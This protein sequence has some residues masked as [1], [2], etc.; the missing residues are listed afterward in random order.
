MLALPAAKAMTSE[1]R[2]LTV[3]GAGAWRRCAFKDLA[4]VGDAVQLA[5]R[6]DAE[7]GP[8]A[9]PADPTGAGLAFDSGCRLL[10]ARPAEG[11]VERVLWGAFDPLHPA[12]ALEAV[13]IIGAP[14]PPAAGDFAPAAV[15][16]SGFVPR[17]LACDPEDRLFI[18]DAAAGMIRVFDLV[19][20]RLLRSVQAP[21]GPVDIAWWGGRLYGLSAG[22][23][24]LWRMAAA[25]SL[26]PVEAP[27]DGLSSP[28]RLTFAADGRCF[29]LDKAHQAD[30]RIFEL[31]RPGRWRAEPRLVTVG[32][33]D[34]FAHASDIV[35]LGEGEDERLVIARR[36]DETFQRLDI[37]SSTYSLA[38]PLTARG[39][40]GA[41][42]AAAPDGR[43]AFWT[44]K[45][46]R[47]A[48]AARTRYRPKGRAVSFRLDGGA[49]RTTWGRVFLD[50]CIPPGTAIRVLSIVS[51]DDDEPLMQAAERLPRTPP[52][53]SDLAPIAEAAAT[54]MPPLVLVPAEEETGPAAVRRADGSEQPWAENL[55]SFATYEAQPSRARGR[56]LWL[57][58]DLSGT[59]LATP[60]LRDVRVER[61]GHDWL[62]RLPALYSRDEQTRGFL[63]AYLAPGAGLI[64]DTAAQ[65]D[66]RHAMLK[67]GS[68]P[69]SVLPWLAG[70]L[71]L[72]LD[73]R[74]PEAAQRT[75]IREAPALF[76]ARGTPA[77][78][79]RMVEI[80]AEAPAVILEDFRLRGQRQAAGQEA[81][82]RAP[83]V[84][85]GGFRVGGPIGEAETTV[86]ASPAGLA[87]LF[88]AAAHRFSILI[89]ADLDAERLAAVRDLLDVH[90]PAHTLV[91]VCT[92]GAGMRVG[93][94]LHV[95]ISSIIGRSADWR[96]L[97]AGA[98]RLG[99]EAIVGR[100]S[101]GLRAGTARLGSPAL[102]IG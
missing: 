59:S 14:A 61:P 101:P 9:A 34:A 19:A 102:R 32:A 48:V 2:F 45:G 62:S 97:Q 90:R 65:G 22:P 28:A 67:P 74:W 47:H 21:A 79:K 53:F 76:R 70:W 8:A 38:E 83:S 95:G 12:R 5:W 73:E 63:Q 17:A 3:T 89:Q 46:V 66:T 1:A 64:E 31:G 10:H 44:A 11:Q 4:L 30:G 92:G 81:G 98:S 43:A 78:L 42:I 6:E 87:T 88:S 27:L 16:A 96:R 25:E 55:D 57:V 60:K 36:P 20:R 15:A 54:P 35:C 72:T 94:G 71:G 24:R 7:A 93:R 52:A 75:M 18:L 99:R 68:A 49:Y 23:A 13:P 91:E 100:P 77:A 85:G 26:R 40:D 33:A 84:L 82:W 69:A 58:F 51:D 80:V 37:A 56:Y 86:T 29:V 50:A 39:Y 41:G